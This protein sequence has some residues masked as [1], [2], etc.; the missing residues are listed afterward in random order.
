MLQ[1][2]TLKFIFHFLINKKFSKRKKL[3]RDYI[4]TKFIT[5]FF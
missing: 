1:V 5:P 4:K 3:K 2:Q